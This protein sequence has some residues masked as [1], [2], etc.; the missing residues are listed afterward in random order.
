MRTLFV[1]TV[2]TVLIP[3]STAQSTNLD[4]NAARA[5]CAK[6]G[7]GSGSPEYDRCVRTMWTGANSAES[8]APPRDVEQAQRRVDPDSLEG[9]LTS[10]YGERC[11]LAGY[12]PGTGAFCQCLL[13]YLDRDEQMGRAIAAQIYQQ[14]SQV[15]P[16]LIDPN[17]FK[18]ITPPAPRIRQCTSVI[19]NQIVQ[20]TCY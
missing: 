12:S 4:L 1:L 2:L 7:Y 9:K 13:A 11:Q 8:S 15:K 20:T 5:Y 14:Q 16:I 18:G 17:L 6:A 3:L 19:G 10:R